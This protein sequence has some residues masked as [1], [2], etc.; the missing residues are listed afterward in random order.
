MALPDN[1][2]LLTGRRATVV[3]SLVLAMGTLVLLQTLLSPRYEAPMTDFGRDLIAGQAVNEGVNPYQQI[4]VLQ[5]EVPELQV[6]ESAEDFWVAH[7]PLSIALARLVFNLAGDSAIDVGR[8]GGTAGVIALLAWVLMGSGSRRVSPARMVSAGA[9]AMS[10]G[11]ESDIVWVQGAGLL[12]LLLGAVVYLCRSKRRA[13]A[14][15]VMG[16]AVAWKPW[17]APMALF[18]PGRRMPRDVAWIAIVA[19]FLTVVAAPFIGGWESMRSWVTEAI[20]A[21]TAAYL[22]YE[23][24]V[25]LTGPH[26]GMFVGLLLFACIILACLAIRQRL[27]EAGKLRLGSIA[28]LGLFPIVWVHYWTA[29]TLLTLGQ[30]ESERLAVGIA[31]LFMATPLVGTNPMATKIGAAAVILILVALLIFDR[32]GDG[33]VS[34]D[35]KESYVGL[36]PSQERT[37]VDR[38]KSQR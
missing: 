8:I 1:M 23:W 13:L 24:N 14:W 38:P 15:A 7:S 6:S 27:T 11:I 21:N 25:S 26:L 12:G 10:I 9:L 2:T 29:L 32:S 3:S 17:C 18:L 37:N 4:A 34:A 30:R 36:G 35:T 5:E 22:R 33:I 16:F 19:L 28:I 31:F 20:P